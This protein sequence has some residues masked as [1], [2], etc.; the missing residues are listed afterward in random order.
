MSWLISYMQ[1]LFILFELAHNKCILTIFLPLPLPTIHTS[2]GKQHLWHCSTAYILQNVSPALAY[3]PSGL[4]KRAG[5]GQLFA[6][7]K[8]KIIIVG[9][10]C[11]PMAQMSWLISYMQQHCI[12]A[13]NTCI[14]DN[15]F[16][17][18]CSYPTYT[19][20]TCQS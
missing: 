3:S 9:C 8:W 15:I 17:Y 12:L 18:L 5:F 16:L 1:N 7:S 6:T 11:L 10:P 13:H 14:T 19:R 4:S 20:E 2:Q